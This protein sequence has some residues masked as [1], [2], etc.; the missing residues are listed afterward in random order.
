[1]IHFRYFCRCILR[2]LF[3]SCLQRLRRRHWEATW[4]RDN[5]APPWG[6]RG[7]SREIVE[8]LE[9]GWLPA[10]GTVL[11]IGCGLGEVAAW[12]S[13][14]AYVTVAIDIAEA[15]VRKGRAMHMHLPSPPEYFAM[16]ICAGRPPDRQYNILIDRGCLH[17]IPRE[18]IPNYVRN[19]SSVAAPDARMLLFVKAFR[20]GQPF[21]D[22]S[23]RLRQ[24]ARVSK[25]FAGVFTIERVSDTYLDR[26]QG[27][28]PQNALPG[29]IFWLIR[30]RCRSATAAEAVSNLTQGDR[31]AEEDEGDIK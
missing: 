7:V 22:P 5:F 10:Q 4:C 3:P 30:T 29:L 18:E 8:A 24:T 12:F 23:E 17:Q 2:R 19:I 16:D 13:E 31:Q 11:D 28:D 6:D 26:Y 25:A 15:A 21:G 27:R 14:R 1:M 9:T 20:D